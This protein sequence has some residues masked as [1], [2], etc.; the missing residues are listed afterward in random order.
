MGLLAAGAIPVVAAG[1]AVAASQPRA[2]FTTPQ[3][4]QA[5]GAYLAYWNALLHA[6]A[7]QDPDDPQ[8]GMYAASA[9]LATLQ[10]NI[11]VSRAHFLV[12]KG[13]VGHDITDISIES[14]IAT[15]TDCVDVDP[16]LLYDSRTGKLEPGQ[17]KARPR[18]LVV[19]T[20]APRG[21]SWAVTKDQVIGTC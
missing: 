14:G 17:Y 20:L 13:H 4:A 9:M 8:L 1:C 12:S 21:K 11:S 10:H 16:W 5:E 19:Y 2:T 3:A 15:L 18:Q 7:A 6:S